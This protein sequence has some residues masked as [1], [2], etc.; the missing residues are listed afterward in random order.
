MYHRILVPLDGGE[1]SETILPH[2]TEMARRFDATLVLLRVSSSLAEV[3]SKTVPPE[4]MAEAPIAVDVAEEV[5]EVEE[6]TAE[7]Y[8]RQVVERL[9]QEGVV[10]EALVVQGEPAVSL[11]EAVKQQNIDLVAMTTHARS[12]L[13]RLLHGSVS[14]AVLHEVHVPVLLLHTP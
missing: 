7:Q 10:C 9:K 14:E 13:G 5:V 2:A 11:A 12:A 8:L 1:L 3:V 4:P 6:E